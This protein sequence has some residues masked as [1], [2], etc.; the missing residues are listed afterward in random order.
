MKCKTEN[1]NSRIWKYGKWLLVK[2]ENSLML[3]ENELI[4]IS[5]AF[6]YSTT[7]SFEGA[8]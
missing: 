1:K 4:R 3:N 6:A 5:L 2:T 8:A 7:K